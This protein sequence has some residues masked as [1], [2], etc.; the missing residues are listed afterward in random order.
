MALPV[1]ETSLPMPFT[2]LQPHKMLRVA[3]RV[4]TVIAVDSFFMMFSPVIA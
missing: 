1:L 4:T 2:V 3:Q